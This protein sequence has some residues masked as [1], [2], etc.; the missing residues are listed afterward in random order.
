M[1][2]TI[3]YYHK[4]NKIN[5]YFWPLGGLRASRG[6]RQRSREGVGE[7][8]DWKAPSVVKDFLGV[9]R[10]AGSIGDEAPAEGLTEVQTLLFTEYPTKHLVQAPLSS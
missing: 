6:S 7:L 10:S 4:F 3:V 9:A 5:R 2:S 8:F 1:I